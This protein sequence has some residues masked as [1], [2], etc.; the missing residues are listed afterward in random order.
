ML[1]NNRRDSVFNDH[2][3]VNALIAVAHDKRSPPVAHAAFL[4]LVNL[5]SGETHTRQ[6][7]DGGCVHLAVD[8][9]CN[10][11]ATHPDDGCM[12]LA[13]LTRETDA[14]EQLFQVRVGSRT[15]LH[16]LIDIFFRSKGFNPHGAFDFLA[17]VIF[18]VTQIEQGRRAVLVR[19]SEGCIIQRL[20]P[21]VSYMDS[22]IRRGAMV[23]AIRNCCFDTEV[24]S[25]HR[26]LSCSHH[27]HVV[28]RRMSGC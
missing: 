20:V 17:N 8:L 10:P 13:N 27:H 6:L 9:V 26:T 4:A 21:Y 15:D 3:L 22:K 12:L 7:I 24:A 23:G 2:A 1:E 5:S 25:S 19:S 28:V 16:R 14:C 18:N 11:T